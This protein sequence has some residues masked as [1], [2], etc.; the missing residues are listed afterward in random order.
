MC[1]VLEH[2]RDPGDAIELL[3]GLVE[4]SGLLYLTVPDAGSVVARLL[5]R[6]WWSI[7]PMHMQYF[8]RSSIRRLLEDRGFV[9]EE[10]R[11]HAKVF[12]ARYYAE[13]LH[14]YSPMLG[15]LIVKVMDASGL[16]SRLVA[17]DLFDRMQVIASR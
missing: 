14:G 4:P 15:R 8:T 11:S 1:D 6:R 10:I 7:L 12:S 3:K 2:L 17:P 9:V 13:R 5:G 16:G